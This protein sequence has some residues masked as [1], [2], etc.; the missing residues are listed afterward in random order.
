MSARP[1]QV[2][3]GPPSAAQAASAPVVT[4]AAAAQGPH[5][6]A[7]SRAA[8]AAQATKGAASTG[9]GNRKRECSI[10]LG[11]GHELVCPT[12]AAVWRRG[13]RGGDCRAPNKR[14]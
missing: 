9:A 5:V 8:S 14:G 6:S 10:D 13:E 7:G 1:T 11:V 4:S 3:A 12:V 2:N